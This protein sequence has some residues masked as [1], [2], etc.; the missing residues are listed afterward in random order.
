[1]L[2]FGSGNSIWLVRST[3]NGESFSAPSKVAELPKLALGRHRGPPSL[4]T[5]SEGHVAAVWLDDRS[6]GGKRLYGAFSNDAGTTWS[7][8]VML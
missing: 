7:K 2:V 4:G 5:P 8:N 3:N 1:V 6:A